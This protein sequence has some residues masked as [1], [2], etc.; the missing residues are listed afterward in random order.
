MAGGALALPSHHVNTREGT[1]SDTTYLGR[2]PT[3]HLHGGT[4]CIKEK[5]RLASSQQQKETKKWKGDQ[6]HLTGRN[7]TMKTDSNRRK[8]CTSKND[9]EQGTWNR[10]SQP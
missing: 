7:P 2:Y 1:Q 9:E 8:P 4:E 6:P 3:R 5:G 10:S